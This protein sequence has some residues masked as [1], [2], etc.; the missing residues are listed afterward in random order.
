MTATMTQ[1]GQ[2]ARDLAKGCSARELAAI[3]TTFHAALVDE[4]DKRITDTLYD[5][6]YDLDQLQDELDDEACECPME[7]VTPTMISPPER[8]IGANRD[9]PVHGRDP[10]AAREAQLE[11]RWECA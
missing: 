11:R 5:A 6:A 1:A 7:R 4:V 9:C 2:L 3:L 8:R 10:D